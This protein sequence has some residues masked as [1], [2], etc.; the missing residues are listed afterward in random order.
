VAAAAHE[1][2]LSGTLE[3]LAP[4]LTASLVDPRSFAAIRRIADCLPAALTRRMYLEYRLAE[5]PPAADFVFCVD[6]SS[7]SLLANADWL[8]G[9]LRQAAAWDGVIRLCS[10]WMRGRSPLRAGIYD[11]W[12]EFDTGRHPPAAD[13]FVPSVFAGLSSAV[14]VERLWEPALETLGGPMGAT[15]AAAVRRSVGAL[16][17]GVRLLYVGRMLSRSHDAVRL[18]VSP[19]NGAALGEYLGRIAWPG[20]IDALCAWLS[21]LA[22]DGQRSALDAATLLHL[23][24]AGDLQPYAGV[25][26]PLDQHRQLISGIAERRLLDQ[27][28]DEGLC[29]EPLR[30]AVTAWPGSS[31]EWLPHQCWPS[32]TMRRVSHVKLVWRAGRPAEAKTYLSY[33]HAFSR[34]HAA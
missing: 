9:E 31:S 13:W 1:Y 15:A 4:H 16:P 6:R 8:P 20:D 7:A 3:R 26:I 25:E 17:E 18:C 22:V 32:L 28:C 14:P 30:A 10:A 2:R 19:L 11:A 12:L 23:D 24:I 29:A 21:S 5:V 27:L 34:R 33:F